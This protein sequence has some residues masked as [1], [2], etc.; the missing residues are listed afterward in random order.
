MRSCA[1]IPPERHSSGYTRGGRDAA[2]LRQVI[3]MTFRHTRYLR[4]S[5]REGVAR[6]FDWSGSISTRAPEPHPLDERAAISS[7]WEAIGRD[8]ARVLGVRPAVIADP[9]EWSAGDA[10]WHLAFGCTDAGA[11]PR[12]ANAH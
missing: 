12:K 1:L 11:S 9:S 6:L 5:F 2:A 7:D 3:P 10:G 8:L 4:P